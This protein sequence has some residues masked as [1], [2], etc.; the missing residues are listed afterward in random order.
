[1]HDEASAL[2]PIGLLAVRL[3][4]SGI[5]VTKGTVSLLRDGPGAAASHMAKNTVFLL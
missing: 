2:S 3:L 4:L 5:S 1:M